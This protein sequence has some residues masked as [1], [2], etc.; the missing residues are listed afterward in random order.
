MKKP[1]T[2]ALDSLRR[3]IASLE[4]RDIDQLYG[5]EPVYEPGKGIAGL[6]PEEFVAVQCPYCGERL[7]TRVDVTEGERSYIEDCQVCC[8]P[9]EFGVELAENGALKAVRVQRVD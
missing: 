4:N 2:G 9:I 1:K 3:R 8:R 6:L 7:D 5:L